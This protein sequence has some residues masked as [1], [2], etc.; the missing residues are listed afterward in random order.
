MSRA[1]TWSDTLPASGY[2]DHAIIRVRTKNYSNQYDIAKQM[3]YDHLTKF[4]VSGDGKEPFIDVWGPTVLAHYCLN[5][6]TMFPGVIDVMSANYTQI[7]YVL[8]F[9]RKLFDGQLALDL[10]KISE[11]RLDITND[12]LTT[13]YDSTSSIELDIDLM[14]LED[15]PAAPPGY[16]QLYEHS[17][18]TWNAASQKHTFKVPTVD[19]IR[20][21][22]LGCESYRT[23]GTGRQ[24]D[25][26]H[27]SLRYLKYMH[28]SGKVILQDNDLFRNDQDAMWGYPDEIETFGLGEARTGYTFDTML[29]RPRQVVAQAAYTSDPGSASDLV[30]DAYVERW[31]AIRRSGTA[32]NQMRW[33]AK[34]YGILDHLCLH[35]DNPDQPSRYIDPN[36]LRD[37]EVEVGNNASGGSTGTIRFILNAYKPQP[38]K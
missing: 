33:A 20:R 34:G 8:M 6:G 25:K 24:T 19:R 11:T 1:S 3:Q 16:L 13:D 12:F 7:E 2:L 26:P 35:E 4:K 38:T 14:F 36:A 28:K 37:V 9:G 10:S 23:S 15:P 18:K 22:M 29:C 30:L 17:T 32:G 21:I 31:L 27:K 5:Q